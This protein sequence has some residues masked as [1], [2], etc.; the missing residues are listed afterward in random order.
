MDYLGWRIKCPADDASLQYYSNLIG[1]D[2]EK[3]FEN[4]IAKFSREG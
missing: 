2:L 4:E 1:K 3:F